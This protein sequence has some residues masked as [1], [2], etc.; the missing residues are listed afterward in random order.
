MQTLES[1]LRQ[2]TVA[3]QR[4]L[5]LKIHDLESRLRRGPKSL[6]PG[7]VVIAIL[8]IV[9]L[10]LSD[11][12]WPIVTVFWV[13]VGGGI[14]I[15]VRHDLKKD[16]R[17]LSGML[18]RYESARERNEAEV[19][20]IKAKAFA[21][22]EET[23]DEGACYAFEIDGDRLAFVQG[24]QFYPE[25]KFPSH[26]FSLVHILD[27]DGLAV[28]VQIDKR[29]PKVAPARTI[30]AATKLGLEIP[31]HLEVLHGQL[32]DIEDLLRR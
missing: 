5:G 14:S 31:E 12:P 16:L 28:D 9:T 30:P 18:R 19:F 25:A 29:G 3:E 6:V 20:D 13:A 2:L 24:Q 11:T 26:D 10:A 27:E 22:F 21:D 7:A 4:L 8:C 17:S 32:D 23:E 15:W 1:S